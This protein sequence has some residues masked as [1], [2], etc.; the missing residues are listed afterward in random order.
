M[1]IDAV[2]LE[3]LC[4]N[5]LQNATTQAWH[6]YPLLGKRIQNMCT[7]FLN[8]LTMWRHTEKHMWAK[9]HKYKLSMWTEDANEKYANLQFLDI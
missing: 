6:M 4:D 3:N 5:F 9:P 1:T 2:W 8:Q 7:S